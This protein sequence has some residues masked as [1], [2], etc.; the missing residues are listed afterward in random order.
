MQLIIVRYFTVLFF[1]LCLMGFNFQ[2]TLAAN[3]PF[4]LNSE[5]SPPTETVD[6][7][8]EQFLNSLPANYYTIRTPEALKKELSDAR[9]ILVDVREVKEYKTGHI[10]GAINIPLRTLT[11]NLTQISPDSKVIVYCSTGYR[12]AMAVMT[13]NL[14]GYENVL[15]F[16]P[17]FTGWE[18]AGEVIV[19]T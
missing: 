17:S 9:T 7:A 3:L 19:K 15:G 5:P 14:L 18:A 4:S 2:P 10:P 6:S 1:A 12:S 8:I 11:H 16:P 13:L